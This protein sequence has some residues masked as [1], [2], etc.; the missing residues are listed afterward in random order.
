MK[1]RMSYENWNK[2]TIEEQQNV[3]ED[4]LPEIPQEMLTNSLTSAVCKRVDGVIGWETTQRLT[5]GSNTRW[6]PAYKQK[7]I[8]GMMFWYRFD[9]MSAT[10]SMNL[11]ESEPTLDEEPIGMYGMRWMDFMEQ[12]HP[13]LV[14]LM[15]FRNNY[16]TVARSVD[17]SAQAYRELLDEQYAQMNPRPTEDYEEI[18]KWEET[19]KFYTDG[20]VMR[21]RV[22]I[23]V[24]TP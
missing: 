23:P 21:E 14:E 20:T 12:Q 2:L 16:L 3:P 10:Y 13:D 24:T 17:R 11:T 1:E 7:E 15:Q 18:R 4:C 19:R 9:P 8:A 22:L 5:N 6:F